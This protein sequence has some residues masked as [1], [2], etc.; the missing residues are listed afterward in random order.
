LNYTR[1]QPLTIIYDITYNILC[2]CLLFLLVI[3][4]AGL[5]HMKKYNSLRNIRQV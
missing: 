3:S 4:Y 2:Q 1:T 5:S